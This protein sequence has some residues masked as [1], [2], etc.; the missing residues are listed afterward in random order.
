MVDSVYEPIEHGELLP[1]KIFVT[2]MDSSHFHWHQDYELLLVLKGSVTVFCG[3]APASLSAG[4]LILVNSKVV[5]GYSGD[6]GNLCLFIQFSPQLLAP[7]VGERQLYHFYLNSTLPEPVPDSGFG[8]FV[9]MAARIGLTGG[10]ERDPSAELR[11]YAYLQLLLAELLDE[12]Q[13]DI[14]SYP[15]S[16]ALPEE[17]KLA[18][19]ISAYA[20]ANC[21]E[22]DLLQTMCEHF[23]LS[24]KTLYRHVKSA[25]GMSAKELID[26]ARVERA[27]SLLRNSDYPVTLVGEKCGF[28]SDVSFHRVFKK[29]TGLTPGTYRSEEAKSLVGKAVQGYL[30]FDK[31]EATE[32]LK[33]F[34]G[35][36]RDK[37]GLQ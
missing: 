11:A 10:G 35:A 4:D 21:E 32:I 17:G 23:H 31:S 28:A 15:L 19:R 18:A 12:V 5:H 37:G 3:P 33:R 30:A 9:E 36:N 20:E 24:E 6:T 13:H 14:R 16:R 26:K 34:A 22:Q 29:E 7:F 27:K 2:S 25:L 1:A 8:H